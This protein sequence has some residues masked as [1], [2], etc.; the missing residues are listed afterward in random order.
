[1]GTLWLVEIF[2]AP[3]LPR[4]CSH[5]SSRCSLGVELGFKVLD[6]LVGF[7]GVHG[8]TGTGVGLAAVGVGHFFENEVDNSLVDLVVA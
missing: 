2:G 5:S 6:G 1:M 3:R 4:R 8:I 7:D